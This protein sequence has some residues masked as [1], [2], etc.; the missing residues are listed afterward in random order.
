M[1]SVQFFS[2]PLGFWILLTKTA[3]VL[4]TVFLGGFK[5]WIT[6]GQLIKI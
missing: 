5:V 6:A 1:V 4:E 3:S 2:K